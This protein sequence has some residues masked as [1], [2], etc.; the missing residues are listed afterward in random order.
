MDTEALR[1]FLAV[2]EQGS[3]SL[4]AQTLHLTQPA[5]SKRIGSLEEQLGCRLFDRIGRGIT[6]TE[7]GRLLRERGEWL[8]REVDGTARAIR[9]LSGQVG[10]TLALATSHHVG[11]HRLPPVL[12]L[13]SE[14]YPEVKLDIDFMDSEAAHQGV[15]AGRLE[16]AVVTLAPD[17][18]APLHAER[19]WDDPLAVMVS[20]HHPLA[21][22]PQVSLPE[23]SHHP[24]VLPGLNT[25]TGQIVQTLFEEH[26]LPLD[27][28]LHTNYLEIIRMMVSVG[29]GWSVLPRSML[30]RDLQALSLPGKTLRRQLGAIHHRNR[31]LSNAAQAFLTL[32][33]QTRTTR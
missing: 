21:R 5:V 22:Q 31:N 10:G 13:F 17:I 27:I 4:A 18:P 30:G 16:L 23:L 24:A 8:L 9:D 6:L 7:A 2:A 29:L 19:I 12:R 28:S 20:H 25:Y 33:R 3:F 11:L 15:L 26:H 14:H 1:A 32:L